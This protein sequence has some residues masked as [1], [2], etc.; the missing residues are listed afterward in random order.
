MLQEDRSYLTAELVVLVNQPPL[1]LEMLVVA[2]RRNLLCVNWRS[3][4][5][6]S[7]SGNIG[8]VSDAVD[9]ACGDTATI[10]CISELIVF[11][12]D[13]TDLLVA[14]FVI[15]SNTLQTL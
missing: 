12:A 10:V 5:K 3:C 9:V 7:I 4:S 6:K 13:C 11:V 15:F 8:S 14:I 1:D 2:A